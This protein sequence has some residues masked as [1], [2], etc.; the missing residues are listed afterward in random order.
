MFL[1]FLLTCGSLI[2]LIMFFGGGFLYGVLDYRSGLTD[3]TCNP[4]EFLRGFESHLQLQNFS[5]KH[6]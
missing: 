2:G 3:R 1:A 4:P 6:F 5:Q